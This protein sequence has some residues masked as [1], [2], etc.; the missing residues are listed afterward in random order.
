MKK[1]FVRLALLA[2]ISLSFAAC[3]PAES[4]TEPDLEDAWIRAMP[5]GMKMTA[6]FGT[7][8][9]VTDEKIA[10]ESFSSPQFR[11]ISLHLSEVVNGVSRMNEVESLSL[12]AGESL[13]M[14]PGGYH[15]MLMG[16]LANIGVG[17]M[18]ELEIS[19]ADGRVFHYNVPVE[20]R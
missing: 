17:Q 11:E 7:L 2:A 10:V 20:K 13:E 15:L 19:T 6:G 4:P 18:V 8:S 3:Q 12:C 14:A 5:P 9:N 1:V 16:P